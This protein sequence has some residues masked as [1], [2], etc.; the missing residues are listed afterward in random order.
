MTENE[1]AECFTTLVGLNPEGGGPDLGAFECD[2]MYHHVQFKVVSKNLKMRLKLH[3]FDSL[4]LKLCVCVGQMQKMCWRVRSQRWFPWKHL[5]VISW[6]SP[7]ILKRFFTPPKRE[8]CPPQDQK[9][10]R[11]Y[12]YCMWECGT[13]SIKDSWEDCSSWSTHKHDWQPFPYGCSLIWPFIGYKLLIKINWKHQM[14]YIKN[15]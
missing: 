3:G 12:M 10:Y 13:H 8:C 5:Q 9:L 1:L 11:N 2:G 14:L 4:P 6:D 15:V 7:F